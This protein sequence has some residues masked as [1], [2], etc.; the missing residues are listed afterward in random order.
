MINHDESLQQLVN[1]LVDEGH[2]S[3]EQSQ[4]AATILKE[5][6]M[7]HI[8]W[9]VQTLQGVGA[10]FATLMFILFF[11][12]SRIINTQE[13]YLI[14]GVILLALSLSLS[15][16]KD[17]KQSTFISQLLLAMSLTGHVLFAVGLSM[18]VDSVTLTA[19]AL[20]LLS[21]VFIRFYSGYLHRFLSVFVLLISM[22]VI[23]YD[24][25]IG[26]I[27]PQ[28]L[29]VAVTVFTAWMWVQESHY[30]VKPL[31]RMYRAIQYALVCALLLGVG[32]LDF[33]GPSY[34]I[35]EEDLGMFSMNN[36][37][38]ITI[39]I[40]LTMLWV[41]HRIYQ[42]QNLAWNSVNGLLLIVLALTLN[43]I[44]FQT[45]AITASLLVL[46]IGIERGNRI[47]IPLAIVT[48]I[49]HIV[50]FYYLLDM[51]LL[52]KSI[53]LMGSG[54]LLTTAGIWMSRGKEERV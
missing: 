2:L 39:G 48:L 19:G 15:I 35:R 14:T 16:N 25:E 29:L 32:W 20:V 30:L 27:M 21:L 33:D 9:F 8:P 37:W 7:E 43:A 51:T 45:P 22:M 18:W 54:L 40:S 44:F 24:L 28:L 47:L 3:D 12:I 1:E 41:I 46:M 34:M 26:Q 11:G 53:L 13:A 42:R 5:E 31:H 23:A 38:V 49:F 4:K 10:W 6:S 52:D 17:E 36:N 50:R